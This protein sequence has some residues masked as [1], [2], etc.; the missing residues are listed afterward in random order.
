MG[1]AQFA[2]VFPGQGAQAP[3]MG[4]SL[5][6]AGCSTDLLAIAEE[7]GLD[8]ERL[9]VSADADELRRTEN[10]QPALFY[11]GVAVGRLLAE[12]EVRPAFAA[13]HSLGEYCAL[14]AAGAISA[15]DGMRLVL[16]RARAMADAPPGTMAAVLGLDSERLA[17]V[18]AAVTAG[19][20]VCVVANDNS[21]GQQVISGTA[22]GVAEVSR[23]ARELGAR[24]VV[25]LEVGGAFHSPLMERA[26]ARF[27]ADVREI[28]VVAPGWPVGSG[29]LGRL[30]TSAAEVREGLEIQ[31]RSPVRWTELVR[32]LAAAGAT[33][34][35]E[36]GPGQTLSG[37]IRR[38]I[39]GAQVIQVPGPAEAARLVG[40]GSA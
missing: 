9:V 17:E 7:E 25:P 6:D 27:A 21:P 20:D 24:K 4:R 31:L 22:A 14:V 37:L 10:A 29:A 39:T 28:E 23:R 3:G 2:L 35:V 1:Q 5:V 30:V 26:A 15:D 32:A 11:T 12:G 8:L 18:C 19:G 40:A 36:C 16:R 34:Y 13:G 38:I 33:R